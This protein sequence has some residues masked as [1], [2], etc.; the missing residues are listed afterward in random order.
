ME[1]GGTAGGPAAQD[2]NPSSQPTPARDT[3]PAVQPESRSGGSP[4]SQDSQA[5]RTRGRS[6]QDR[7]TSPPPWRVEGMPDSKQGRAG[8]RPDWRRFL[9]IMLALLVLNWLLASWLASAAARTTVS[10]TFFWTQV[11]ANNVQTVTS[12]GDS[13]QGTFRHQVAYPPGTASSQQTQVLD[14]ATERPTFANDNLFGKL[15]ANGVTVNANAPS[16]G[17]PLWED[18]LLWFGPAVLFGLLLYWW[19][20]SGAGLGGLGGMGMGKSGARRYD[21]GSAQRTTFADVAGIQDVKDEVMEIVDFLRNPGRYT[22]LGAQIPHGVLLAGAPGTGKT[23]LARAVAGEADVPFF[24]I[25]ASEFVEMIV[26][27]GASRVRD[28][29]DQAKQ[30]APAIIF[31]DEIDAIGRQRGGANAMGSNDE[32]E[33]TLDQILTE[34][35]G[36]TGNEGVVVLAATN[37]ADVLDPALLRPGRFDRRVTVS[38][39]DQRGRRQILAVHTRSVPLAPDADL[40]A[41]AA[42]TPGMVGADLANLVNE[43]A[44]LAARR[45]H[46]QV[47]MAD[48]NDSL[49]K[50]ELGTIRGIVLSPQ[51]RERTAYH[52]SGHALL[53]MLTPGA[54]PV[55]QISIIPRGQSLGATYQ[56]PTSDRYGYSTSYLRGRITGALGGRASEEIVYGDV[57]TGAESDLDNASQIARQMVGR[58]GMSPAIGP[59]TVLPPPGQE[60]PYSLDGIA[61]AT[62]ELID[63]E[64]RRIIEECYA[65]AL[66]TLRDNR[67]RLDRLAHTLL[68]KETLGQ[69][70]AYTAAGLTSDTAPAAPAPA[71]VA[72]SQ[73]G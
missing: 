53:G 62:R 36:F 68:E 5:D 27:V 35:D 3:Q 39:P 11:N 40:D 58:W 60:S 73:A 71:A 17:T 41:V 28:L 47:T 44:L 50:A 22:R 46:D 25:S 72:P 34:M 48:F 57:T 1:R 55:R 21:S 15:Q 65:Q 26:G 16:Q 64:A 2:A 51:E 66:Q 54:D 6:R 52:E 12:T 70:E 61:P 63:T 43:A 24:S 31:I 67:D 29:F 49:E 9:W 32:Q 45:N 18:L 19:M 7:S 56:A 38:A 4:D 69:D 8:G 30:V 23:L 10:Y 37:R 14:F 33:Q 42:Q 20:R 59:L 13:I